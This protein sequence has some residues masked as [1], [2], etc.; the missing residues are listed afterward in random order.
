MLHGAQADLGQVEDLPGRH[1]DHRCQH[2]VGAALPAPLGH[3]DDDLVRVID[4]GQVPARGTGL[5]AGLA[6]TGVP[7][8]RR[9]GRLAEPVRGRRLGG[10]ARVPG[11]L[12]LQLR[13]PA[14]GR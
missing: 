8:P 4:L 6:T 3:V 5:L 1:P 13:D 12:A 14:A 11:E 2:Q 9:D 10:I 7:L